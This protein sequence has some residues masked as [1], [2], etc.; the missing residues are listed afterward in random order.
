MS[1]VA[2]V[3]KTKLAV[4]SEEKA[5]RRRKFKIWFWSSVTVVSLPIV[6]G[7]FVF[8]QRL[9]KAS[10][11]IHNLPSIMEQVNSQASTI[12]SSDGETLYSVQG[13]YRR[14]VSI[15]NVPQ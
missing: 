2:G 5:R 4:P 9:N 10:L 13:Q 3:G 12:L 8:N 6:V 1:T 11:L 15:E 14:P 7:G